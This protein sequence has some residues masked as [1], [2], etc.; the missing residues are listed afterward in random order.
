MTITLDNASANI[1][2]MNE[3]TDLL[4]NGLSNNLFL[5]GKCVCHIMNLIVN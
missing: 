4:P 2:C 5:H 3:L 1:A